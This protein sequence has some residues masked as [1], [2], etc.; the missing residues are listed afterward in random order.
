MKKDKRQDVRNKTSEL[1]D[2]EP[3]FAPHTFWSTQPVPQPSEELHLP[4][5]CF[6][7]AI[8]VQTLEEVRKE[9]YALPENFYWCDVD[10]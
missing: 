9:P 6:N 3:L 1:E 8:R 7:T 10:L 4:E 5:S 2:I